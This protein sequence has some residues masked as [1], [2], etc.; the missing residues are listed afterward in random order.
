MEPAGGLPMD[1]HEAHR[2]F[3]DQLLP[4]CRARLRF[5]RPTLQIIDHTPWSP[6]LARS[7]IQSS[8]IIPL[9]A[10][11]AA[12]A[13]PDLALIL[14]AQT[15]ADAPDTLQTLLTHDQPKQAS[16]AL[17]AALQASSQQYL[18]TIQRSPAN[19]S[20]HSTPTHQPTY[21]FTAPGNFGWHIKIIAIWTVQHVRGSS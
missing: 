4:W 12:T 17:S 7:H 14:R 6:D 21:A 15:T 16:I 1:P 20:K 3:I 19:S 13:Q 18:S 10:N 5:I 2:L 9:D 11:V 8:A